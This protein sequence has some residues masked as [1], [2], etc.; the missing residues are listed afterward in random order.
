MEKSFKDERTLVII[1]PDGVQR[2]LI[3]EIVKRYERSGPKLIATKMIIPTEDMAI[4]HYY[5]VG[6]DA[7]L[8]EV[9]RKAGS[10]MR[11]RIEISL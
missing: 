8:E 1:K 2:S 3:G 5:E 9:G 7:W 11:K 6:G 10:H 4:K